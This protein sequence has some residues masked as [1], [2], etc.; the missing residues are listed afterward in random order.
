MYSL[1]KAYRQGHHD[2]C[3]CLWIRMLFLIFF[4]NAI[5]GICKAKP[6]GKREM[7]GNW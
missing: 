5:P 4:C 2:H 1:L 3:V 7:R 6:S